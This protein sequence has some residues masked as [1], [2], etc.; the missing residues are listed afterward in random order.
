MSK[1]FQ[2]ICSLLQHRASSASFPTDGFV[3]SFRNCLRLEPRSDDSARMAVESPDDYL[4]MKHDSANGFAPNM[5]MSS[6]MDYSSKPCR[7]GRVASSSILSM[8]SSKNGS[9][10]RNKKRGV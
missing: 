3:H 9:R 5:D 8:P 1:N 7:N 2:D 6:G 10:E 4:P